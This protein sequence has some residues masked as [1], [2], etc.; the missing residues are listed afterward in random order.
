MIKTIFDDLIKNGY[1]PIK[2]NRELEKVNPPNTDSHVKKSDN[3]IIDININFEQ[4]D[5]FFN[6]HKGD[7]KNMATVEEQRTMIAIQQLNRKVPEVTLRDLFAMSSINGLGLTYDVGIDEENVQR[8]ANKAY[9][10]ADAM[11]EARQKK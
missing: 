5:E 10:I 6:K 2:R 4:I 1:Q 7:N 11:L 8:Y 3:S 9:L